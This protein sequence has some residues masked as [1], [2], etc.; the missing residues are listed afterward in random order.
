MSALNFWSIQTTR[1]CFPHPS[2]L[3]WPSILRL[4]PW[5]DKKPSGPEGGTGRS[6]GALSTAMKLPQLSL[7]SGWPRVWGGGGEGL[8][9]GLVWV[10]FGFGLGICL[11]I[12]LRYPFPSAGAGQPSCRD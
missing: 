11:E 10:R 9:L 5:A 3:C 2:L 1:P 4:G 8:G 6:R 7:K 12:S